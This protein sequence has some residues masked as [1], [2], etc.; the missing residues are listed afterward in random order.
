MQLLEVNDKKTK[1]LFHRVPHLIYKGDP[2]WACPLEIMVEN[3]FGQAGERVVVE[4]FL[5]GEE[6]SFIVMVDGRH[7]LPLATSQG[8]GS[9]RRTEEVP[10]CT[11][12]ART[13]P[14]MIR[15]TI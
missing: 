9:T 7:I 6:V 5:Q 2:N 8:G 3:I 11:T 15:H 12:A 14:G 4:E 13:T 10:P 1:E